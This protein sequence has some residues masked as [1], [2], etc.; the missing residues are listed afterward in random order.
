MIPRSLDFADSIYYQADWGGSTNLV[1]DAAVQVQFMGGRAIQPFV[2]QEDAELQL[3]SIPSRG[4]H[5]YRTTLPKW[6]VG[7]T[8]LPPHLVS[9]SNGTIISLARVPPGGRGWEEGGKTEG[10]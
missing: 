10:R 7:I 9:P 6:G 3:D 1:P 8:S 5:G 2:E 4:K